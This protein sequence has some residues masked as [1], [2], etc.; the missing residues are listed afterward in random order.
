VRL[1]NGDILISLTLIVLVLMAIVWLPSP[2]DGRVACRKLT[3]PVGSPI[4]MIV[5]GAVSAAGIFIKVA[6][7]PGSV[8]NHIAVAASLVV[9]PIVVIII[10]S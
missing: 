3:N 4:D 7:A 5:V 8:D 6:A 1:G 10:S 9:G 2:V